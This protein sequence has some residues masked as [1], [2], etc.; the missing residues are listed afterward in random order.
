M[1]RINLYIKDTKDF[2]KLKSEVRYLW[3]TK[4]GE[5]LTTSVLVMKA[6]LY[7]KE[8]LQE[9]E[10]SVEKNTLFGWIRK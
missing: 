9:T 6:L 1:P 4:F 5:S 8:R 3:Y 7:L 10:K 2:A